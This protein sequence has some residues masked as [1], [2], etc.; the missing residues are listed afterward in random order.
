VSAGGKPTFT[1]SAHLLPAA[2]WIAGPPLAL[3][4]LWLLRRSSESAAAQHRATVGEA[5]P[6]PE[7]PPPP[8]IG[9]PES[10]KASARVPRA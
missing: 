1:G 8:G 9:Q 6:S 2:L 3:Y 7:L 5:S 4:G 10:A